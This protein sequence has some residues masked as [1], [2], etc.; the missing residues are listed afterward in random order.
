M[1]L[2]D[3]RGKFETY[4]S[5]RG[6]GGVARRHYPAVNILKG[7]KRLQ[8]NWAVLDALGVGRDEGLVL[9]FS[10]AEGL[11]VLRAPASKENPG[12]ILKPQWTKTG[13]GSVN[14]A[15]FVDMYGIDL[16]KA[17]GEYRL[18]YDEQLKLHMFRLPAGSW[19]K[20]VSKRLG[21]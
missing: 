14:I 2:G 7:S 8:F 6:S 16:E 15:G 9:M 3:R 19:E 20:P 12:A 1:P 11:V 21:S 18:G 10:P 17:K 5:I 13:I 4:V